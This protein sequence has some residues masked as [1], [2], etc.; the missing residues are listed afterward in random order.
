[1][2]ITFALIA[3]E[4]ASG[5]A[6]T[7]LAATLGVP[8]ARQLA[9]AMLL[10]TPSTR[11]TA[12][13]LT[14]PA[15]F[16]ITIRPTRRA[17]GSLGVPRRLAMVPQVEGTLGDRLAHLA[18]AELGSGASCCVIA[19]A[20]SPFALAPAILDCVPRSRDE[21]VLAPCEDAVATGQWDCHDPLPSSQCR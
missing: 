17:G 5:R 6:K 11:S 18:G 15:S 20:D 10:S 21:V 14:A 16:L 2:T 3:K 9:E 12:P 7:R 4:P 8:G 13:P 1:M 19:A